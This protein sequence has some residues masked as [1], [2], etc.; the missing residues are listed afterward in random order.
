MLRQ[1]TSRACIPERDSAEH[2][3]APW[4]R[5]GCARGRRASHGGAEGDA[6]GRHQ[7]RCL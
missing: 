7:I 1:F 6:K 4:R 5:S 3:H 2:S